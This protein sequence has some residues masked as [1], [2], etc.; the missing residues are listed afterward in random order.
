VREFNNR[1][2]LDSRLW[3]ARMLRLACVLPTKGL[4]DEDGG[5]QNAEQLPQD[6]SPEAILVLD[7]L[8]VPRVPPLAVLVCSGTL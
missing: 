8:P 1:G 5:R 7:G 6:G 3:R 4:P 2:Q